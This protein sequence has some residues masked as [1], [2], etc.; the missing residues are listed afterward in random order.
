MLY[1]EFHKSH[2][3]SFHFISLNKQKTPTSRCLKHQGVHSQ[4]DQVL[5]SRNCYSRNNHT[6]MD[7]HA[8]ILYFSYYTDDFF[9]CI[10]SVTNLF[11]AGIFKIKGYTLFLL[12]INI[13]VYMYLNVNVCHSTCSPF[14][15]YDTTHQGIFSRY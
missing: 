5:P 4:Y 11:L 15:Y 9:E 12:Q 14:F 2:C 1:V 7:R 3:S 10:C 8:Y 6:I 13:K